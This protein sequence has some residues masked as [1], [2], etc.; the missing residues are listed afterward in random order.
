MRDT[1]VAAYLDRIGYHGST[2]PTAETLRA[3]H[4]AHLLAVP[5]ENLDI[6]LG[7]EILLEE[8]ALADKI[9]RRRRG[10]FCYELNGLLALLLC[11]LGYRVT[12]LAARVP[13]PDGGLGPPFDHLTL[14][15]EGAR[16]RGRWLADVGWGRQAP[17]EPL[18]FVL[19]EEQV[20]PRD[21]AAYLL[22]EAGGW[23]RLLCRGLGARALTYASGTAPVEVAPGDEAVWEEQYRFT[24]QGYALGDF[25]GGCR[26][27]QTSPDSVFTR[28]RICTRLT[29]DGRITLHD[30][31]LITT[32]HGERTEQELAGEAECRA[33]LRE[34]FGVDLAGE[35]RGA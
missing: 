12:L 4:Q 28:G 19:A 34:Q 32:V 17:S 33:V 6:G 31:R 3:L 18:R 22:T 10:G 26:Y 30:A 23:W 24:L 8:A 7:R 13:T 2:A 16:L 1:D 11:A 15:V 5:F 35:G 9:V 14:L 21:G 20:R 25:A 29:A 27:H